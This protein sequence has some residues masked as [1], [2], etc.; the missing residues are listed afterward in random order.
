MRVD[1]TGGLAAEDA[2]DSPALA[3][4]Y[5][6]KKLG[7]HVDSSFSESHARLQKVGVIVRSTGGVGGR[8]KNEQVKKEQLVE[9]AEVICR[10]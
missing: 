2:P 4:R 6:C 8:K 1:L 3:A 7:V 5:D 9:G 10:S